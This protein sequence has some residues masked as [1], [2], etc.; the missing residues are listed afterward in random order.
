ME[1]C[2]CVCG[3]C[4]VVVCVYVCVAPASEQSKMLTTTGQADGIK[5]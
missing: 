4:V 2:V 1:R 5:C 3:V